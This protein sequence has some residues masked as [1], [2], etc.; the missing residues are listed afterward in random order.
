MNT[1]IPM[2]HLHERR[3]ATTTTTGYVP[4]IVEAAL[5]RWNTLYAQAQSLPKGSDAEHAVRAARL[6][7][8]YDRRARWWDVLAAW[9]YHRADPSVPLVFGHAAQH[10]AGDDRDSARFWCEL[11]A[12]WHARAVGEPTSDAA[13]ALSNHHE[14]GIAS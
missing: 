12:D 9:A 13:G 8:L 7:V 10:C 4:A 6:G 3:A 5:H 1:L 14:L 11:A 2:R